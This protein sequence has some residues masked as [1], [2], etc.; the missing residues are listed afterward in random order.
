MAVSEGDRVKVHYVGS[1]VD[2]GVFDTSRREVAEEEGVLDPEREYGPLSFEVGA[3]DMIEGFEEGVVGMEE[4][5]VGEIEVPPE[6]GYGEHSEDMV[7]EYDYE[8]FKEV[9]GS[10]P[11]EGMHIHGEDGSHGDIRSVGDVVEVDFNH[12]LAGETLVFEVEVVE[13]N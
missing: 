12:H 13:V 5:E 6:K 2:G 8:E 1:F 9:L 4:G 11:E 3:G 7:Q 10:E